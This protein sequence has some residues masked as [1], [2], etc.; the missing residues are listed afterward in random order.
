MPVVFRLFP[1]AKDGP[2]IYAFIAS[3]LDDDGRLTDAYLTLPDEEPP[4]KNQIRFASGALDGIT[5]GGGVDTEAAN[6]VARLVAD[7]AASPTKKN[8]RRLY[9]VLRDEDALSYVDPMLEDLTRQQPDSDAIHKLAVW[10]TTTAADR[11]P[12]KIGLA[13]L[14]CIGIGDDADVV[15]VLG[16]HDEFTLYAAVAISNG[17]VTPEADLWEMAKRVDGWGRIHCVERLAD[18]DDDQIRDWILRTGFRNAVMDEYLAYIAATTGG[19][20]AALTTDTVDREL[21]TAAGRIITALIEGGPAEDISDYDDAPI[22]ITAYLDHMVARAETLDDFHAIARIE[23]YLIARIETYLQPKDH[24]QL[25]P[26]TWTQPQVASALK[27]AGA[28]LDRDAWPDLIERGLRSEDHHTAWLANDAARRSGIDT[29]SIHVTKIL[30]DPID[31]PWFAAWQAARK[32]HERASELVAIARDTFTETLVATGPD[33]ALGLGPEHALHRALDWT[34][35]ELPAHPGLGRELIL[36]AL[37]SPVTRNRN[38]AIR[39]LETW[40]RH[41]WPTGAPEALQ[42]VASTDPYEPLRLSARTLLDL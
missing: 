38:M 21:L 4:S 36:I 16:T 41:E 30:A 22:A 14:G 8:L 39:S 6:R 27:T 31:G 37:R 28:I 20:L 9:A 42:T 19:L 26:T 25:E 2:S 10:L 29:Y 15:R 40:P 11:G 23:T 13:L 24:Q 18:T 33:D 3:N 35:Q 1:A 5:R 17:S 7:T 12:V 34:L 32:S